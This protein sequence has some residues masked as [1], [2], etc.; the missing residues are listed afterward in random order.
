MLTITNAK[1]ANSCNLLLGVA[2]S[3]ALLTAVSLVSP[4]FAG[5]NTD[6]WAHKGSPRYQ[7]LIPFASDA[8]LDKETGLVWERTPAGGAFIWDDAQLHCNTLIVDAR[9]GWRLPTL[10]ELTSQL[11]IG[12]PPNNLAPNPFTIPWLPNVGEFIWSATTSAS[13]TTTAW[14]MNLASNVG[15]FPKGSLSH[16][17]CVRFRQGVDPQ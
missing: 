8:V 3:V 5:H 1:P 16:A 4:V 2:I 11:D 6:P 7:V 13:N 15:T 14:A 10:Q 12:A 17:W 9:M